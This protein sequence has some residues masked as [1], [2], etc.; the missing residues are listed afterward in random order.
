MQQIDQPVSTGRPAEAPILRIVIGK[1]IVPSGIA[2][3]SPSNAKRLHS[4]EGWA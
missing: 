4:R 2:W 3:T 1:K